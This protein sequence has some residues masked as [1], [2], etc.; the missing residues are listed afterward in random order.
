MKK[1]KFIIW[2]NIVT[3][4]LSICAIAIGVYSIT[5]A[6]LNVNG[7]IGFTAHECNV[8]IVASMYGDSAASDSS[9][10][11]STVSGVLR[12]EAHA[13]VYDPI[14]VYS[15]TETLN[16]GTLYFC[17]KTENGK[18][19]PITLS[20][21]I[22]N[23]SAYN[24]IDVKVNQKCINNNRIFIY[25]PNNGETLAP[26]ETITITIQLQLQKVNGEYSNIGSPLNLSNA[27]LLNFTKSQAPSYLAINWKTKIGFS[28]SAVK[29]ISFV[30]VVDESIK[31]NSN[32]T[33]I[34]V[35]AVNAESEQSNLTNN[36]SVTDIIAYYNSTDNKVIVYSPARIYAPK[37]CK[38]MFTN[39]SALKNLDLSNFDTSKVTSMG[40][41]MFPSSYGMFSDCS[42]LTSLD[43]SKFD[44]SSVT[45]MYGMFWGC[46]ALTSLD[47]RNFN[48]SSV[49]N[50]SYMFNGCE[51]LTS[52]DVSNFNTS[53]VTNM[54]YMFIYCR[55]LTSLDVSNFDTSKVTNMYSMFTNCSALTSLDVSKFDTSSVTNMNNMF[56]SCGKI[57]S[58]DLS[59]FNTSKVTDMSGMFLGCSELATIYVNSTNWKTGGVTS[60]SN[61]FKNCTKLVGG[62]GTKF[63]SSYTD[64]TYARVD[65]PSNPGYLTKK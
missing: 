59:N 28:S 40:Y 58:L 33:Q 5:T 61:M 39:C 3:I 55:A 50:M 60:S 37:S 57:K 16:L 25:A 27:T 9:T 63:N 54:S 14:G 35:G 30:N 47:V 4:C 34:K 20:F 7:A 46:S 64:K 24:Y 29:S 2:L 17:D 32:Y 48:T 38:D 53:R 1:R 31:S 26:R 42:A 45:N 56:N 43:V 41:R 13:K 51:V 44:T 62:A 52:L 36:T 10:A 49:T 23:K 8:D 65:A 15:S 11:A 12:S 6:K 18:I 22:T 21:S 19:S